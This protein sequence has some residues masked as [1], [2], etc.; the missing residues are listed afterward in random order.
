MTTRGEISLRDI[1]HK[2]TFFQSLARFI[3]LKRLLL[4]TLDVNIA[5][6]KGV[7]VYTPWVP[8]CMKNLKDGWKFS[9][10]KMFD[11]YRD[12]FLNVC[13]RG[14]GYMRIK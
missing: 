8:N 4:R 1:A 5:F 10:P 14:L 13:P 12:L 2:I 9:F 3:C 6:K 11:S 7:F